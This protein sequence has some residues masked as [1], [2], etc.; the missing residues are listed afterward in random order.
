MRYILAAALAVTFLAGCNSS[1]GPKNDAK[2][3]PKAETVAAVAKVNGKDIPQAR[4]DFFVKQLTA[5]GQADSPEL[6]QN[7][8][9]ELINR[10]IVSQEAVNKGLDKNPDFA[11][12]MDVARQNLLVGAYLKQYA[13][14][15]PVKEEELKAEYEKIKAQQVPTKEYLARHILVEKEAEA[16]TIIAQLKKGANFNELAIEKSKDPGSKIKGGE[17]SWAPATNYVKPFADALAALEKGE[18]T[19]APVQSEFGWHVIKLEDE[20]TSEALPYEE[21]KQLIQ[22]RLQKQ[23]LEKL[24]ADLRAKA[25]VE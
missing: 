7:V 13:E 14:A 22:Q 24:L 6:R 9:E 25:K 12:Q 4:V 8:R 23:Q 15:N 19:T 10:E 21:V 20:R 17:L 2:T 18:Y 3:E 1:A 11:A 5:Q 16:K